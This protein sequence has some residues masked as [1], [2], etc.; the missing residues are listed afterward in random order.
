MVLDSFRL[1]SFPRTLDRVASKKEEKKDVSLQTWTF[2][3][4]TV[5][6]RVQP[7]L[8]DHFSPD[9]FGRLKPKRVFLLIARCL[10]Q[11]LGVRLSR[12]FKKNSLQTKVF[13]WND[14]EARKNPKELFSILRAMAAF[15]MRRD[16]FLVAAGGGVV[17]DVG[18]LAAALYMRGIR[19]G[20]VPTTL[21][22]QVDAAL[23]GKTAVDFYGVKNLIGTFYQPE[24]VWVDPVVLRSLPE[25]QIRSG[26]AEVI[27]YGVIRDAA[28][29][30][31]LEEAPARRE[32]ISWKTW[33][34]WIQRSL[35]IKASIVERDEQESGL[36]AILNFGHTFGHALEAALNYRFLT[37]GEAVAYGMAAAARLA[38]HLKFCTG[39]LPQRLENLLFRWKLLRPFSVPN[40]SLLYK[41]MV[42]DKKARSEGIRLIL[43]RRIGLVTITSGLS[44]SHVFWALHQIRG[45][46]AL[47][48]NR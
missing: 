25:R 5:R 27:K 18:A 39:Q 42:W 37:H 19:L 1:L 26:M 9:I 28:F 30:R 12:F 21:L 7:H 13:A 45:L 11:P 38:H 3:G 35:E 36:R 46:A 10:H 33:A 41:K 40:A 16:D 29:F 34:K 48:K 43:T 20:L 23:G 22:A 8:L 32:E 24:A 4:K 17:T 15:R 44:K 47:S 14:A 2:G 31:E 6:I